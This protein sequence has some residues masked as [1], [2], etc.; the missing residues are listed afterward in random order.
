[1]EARESVILIKP[2][3]KCQWWRIQCNLKWRLIA[4]GA[5]DCVD[6]CREVYLWTHRSQNCLVLLAPRKQMLWRLDWSTS[7]APNIVICTADKRYNSDFLLLRSSR[8]TIGP[9]KYIT[10]TRQFSFCLPARLLYLQIEFVYIFLQ[11][12]ART[13]RNSSRSSA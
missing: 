1:M 3:L 9:V 10:N 12:S 5:A 6:F 8:T 7:S 2:I 11:D 13:G 4:C